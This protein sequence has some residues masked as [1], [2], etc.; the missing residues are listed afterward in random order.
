MSI[1][2][3]HLSDIH[4][5]QEKGG[6]IVIH[7]DAKD[8]LVDDVSNVV[9][10]LP[11]G[12][13]SGVIVSGDIAY[14]GKQKEY[15]DAG[16]WFDRVA[17]AA[18]CARTDIQLVPGNHDI[19]REEISLA[20]SLLLK[21]IAEK[22]EDKLDE[23]LASEKDREYLYERFSAY[24]LFA[25]AY[26]SSLDV[27]GG[28][29]GDRMV[30]LAPGRILHFIGLNTALI[31]SNKDKHG[32]LLL[33]ARQRVLPINLGH[34][35]VV[36]AH[37]PLGWLKDS[38]DT[39]RF[40]TSR[41]RIFMTGHE[42]SP[43]VHIEQIEEGCDLMTIESGATI[44]P[45]ADDAYT[46]TYNIIEFE[47]DSDNDALIVKVHT[48]KWSEDKKIFIADP[49]QL[50]K[51]FNLGCPNFRNA[52]PVK[53]DSLG[54]VSNLA[55]SSTPVPIVKEA[56]VV[57]VRK[58]A[59]VPMQYSLLRLRFF[60]DLTG[61]QRQ[62]VLVKLKAIPTEF[63]QT[64][65]HSMEQKILDSLQLGNRLND[66]ESAINEI[67]MLTKNEDDPND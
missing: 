43:S 21:E 28:N 51:E 64:L 35:L 19:D 26:N 27:G 66:L 61:P 44:P 6:V 46:Y 11:N 30:E 40:L 65:T 29:A 55:L 3:V 39:R 13:A 14:A 60:R 37:H 20:M 33:G 22:G 38:K 63:R 57:E 42:H 2:F 31:C 12:F 34:E 54:A 49:E 9:K 67:E 8:R 24:R 58:E 10:T 1:A 15:E 52:A 25:A 7:D 16:K 23:C 59:A 18:G 53:T 5:G 62:S 56:N 32:E 41:A 48:R 36:I 45:A 4:F 17:E 47:W 50:N